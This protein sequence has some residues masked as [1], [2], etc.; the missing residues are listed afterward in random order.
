MEL[1]SEMK[2]REFYGYHSAKFDVFRYLWWLLTEKKTIHI[3][4][5]F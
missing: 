5:A 1:G 3:L 2:I 4:R